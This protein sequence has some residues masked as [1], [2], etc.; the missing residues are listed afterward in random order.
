[1]SKRLCIHRFIAAIALLI[2]LEHSVYSQCH[3][4]RADR[5]GNVWVIG[6]GEVR[7]IDNTN[8]L[9]GSYSNLLLGSP[10]L[11]DPADPFRVAVFY[12]KSQAIV[13]LNSK[14]A[15]VSP[16][17]FLKNLAIGEAHSVCRSGNGGLWVFDRQGWTIVRFDSHLKPTG[18]RVI[19]DARL[20]DTPCNFMQE[21][22]GVL[23]LG[24]NGLGINRY[25]RY[26]ADMGLIPIPLGEFA[27]FSDKEIIYTSE[28]FVFNYSLDENKSTK[29]EIPCPCL[30][31]MI[32]GRYFVF[33][34]IRLIACGNETE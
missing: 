19:P 15:E 1:M 31:I 28:G 34:G 25:D 20:S 12:Q 6:N 8:R 23:Y 26:G 11:V 21:H 7:L 16:P 3:Y 13:I 9:L 2:L 18:E 29:L 14:A 30:P 5:F 33:D 17:V 32:N 27:V 4:A 22:G 10:L 24:F